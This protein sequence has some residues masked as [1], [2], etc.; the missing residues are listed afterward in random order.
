MKRWILSLLF[1]P[2][3][4]AAKAEPRGALETEV[5][6]SLSEQK[7][8][9]ALERIIAKRKGTPEEAELWERKSELYLKLARSARFFAL[10]KT[11]EKTLSFLP[12]VV[13]QKSNTT[14]LQKA[15]ECFDVI[16]RR[17]PKYPDMDRIYFHSSLTS[18]QLGRFNM[19]R[20]QI[21][22]L[23]GRH[24]KSELIPDAHLLMGELFFDQKQFSKALGHFQKAASSKKEKVSQYAQYKA[25]WTFYNLQ[26]NV[27]AIET[28]K[29]LIKS[30][31]PNRPEGFALRNEALRDTALFMTETKSIGDAFAFFKSFATEKETGEA[32]LRM[33]QIYRSHSRHKEATELA[34]LYLK[35]G[36][37]HPVKVNFHLSFATYYRESGKGKEGIEHL[38]KAAEQCEIQPGV[39]EACDGELKTQI[40]ETAEHWWKK[41]EKKKS[42]EFLGYARSALEVE[43]KRNPNPRPQA[44]EAYA[45]LLFSSED[46]ENASRVYRELHDRLVKAKEK[47]KERLEKLSYASLVSLDRWMQKQK[48]KILPQE[49]FKEQ[50][51]AYLKSYP[52]S[53]HK[54]ELLL[55]WAALDFNEGRFDGSEKKLKSVLA[56]KPK[57]EI[58][59]PTQNQ[60]LESLRNQKKTKD[61]QSLLA[62]WLKGNVTKERRTELSRLQASLQLDDI[63]AQ[64][65]K[66]DTKA[67]IKDHLAF[68]KQYEKDE[69]VA[70]PVL[71]KTLGLALIQKDDEL[72]LSLVEKL[73]AKHPKDPRIWDSLKQVLLRVEEIKKPSTIQKAFDLSLKTVPPKDRPSLLWSYRE[74]L[75]KQRRTAEATK[76]DDEIV[77]SGVE[78]ERSLILVARLEKDFENGKTKKVFAES[79][80]FMGKKLPPVVRAR[81]RILQAKVLESELMQQRVKS[82]LARLQNVLAIK[83][84]RLSKAQEAYVSALKISSEPTIVKVASEG[85]RRCFEHSIHALKNLEVKD[86]LTP[87]EKKILDEQIQTLVAPLESQLKELRTAE[88]Q[89]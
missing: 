2:S 33:V 48:D 58:L 29:A 26:K 65:D 14:P 68:I 37:Y 66:K 77:R 42:K 35:R 69:K 15:M 8:I 40:T 53:T 36:A 6:V 74:H 71:W 21:E 62:E 4:A 32:L 89:L 10:N 83:L 39:V 86:E 41:W 50:V 80:K 60:L 18:A 59:I 27:E 31:D 43:I 56:N 30:V 63:E 84:E 85:L 67:I 75:L 44:M 73:S 9:D 51:D 64:A 13:R 81:A 24:P 87:E 79:K 17:F 12:P 1:I 5:L 55:K 11:S 20:V 25:G 54:N 7:A 45:E 46:F 82:S 3:P 38:A 28:L 47:D 34:N 61:M 49:L 76:I 70:E 78:P 57:A 52:N 16:E 88:A 22:K 72:T 19:A 23:L